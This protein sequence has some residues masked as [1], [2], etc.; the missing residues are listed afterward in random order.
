MRGD[1]L[2]LSDGRNSIAFAISGV[3]D[4]GKEDIGR[5]RG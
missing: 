2:A 1:V 3:V 4:A 5:I